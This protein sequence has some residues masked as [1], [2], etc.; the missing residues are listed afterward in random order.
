MKLHII[1]IFL[2]PKTETTLFFL[3]LI[4]RFSNLNVLL[5]GLLMQDLIFRLGMPLMCAK[6]FI[7]TSKAHANQGQV[8]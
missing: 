7:L 2:I 8:S 4:L 6:D 1:F 5:K 3:G